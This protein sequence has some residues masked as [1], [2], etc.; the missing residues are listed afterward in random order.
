MSV[1][2]DFFWGNK[3]LDVLGSLSAA[4]RI[5]RNGDLFCILYI[6]LLL[7][8]LLLLL[9]FGGEGQHLVLRVDF[10]HSIETWLSIVRPSSGLV[11]DQDEVSRAVTPVRVWC[12]R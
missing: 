8:L 4:G 6:F 11:R 3:M 12:L 1:W 7:L 5:I 2:I 9:L 10:F